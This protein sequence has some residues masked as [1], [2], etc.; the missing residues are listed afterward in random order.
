MDTVTYAWGNGVKQIYLYLW[1]PLFQ[2]QWERWDQQNHQTYNYLGRNFRFDR[3]VMKDIAKVNAIKT[4]VGKWQF[5]KGTFVYFI[6]L[7]ANKFEK[8]VR[9]A[10]CECLKLL[11]CGKHF[12]DC[13]ISIKGDF[14]NKQFKNENPDAPLGF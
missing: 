6:F 9:L 11:V 2:A 7:N 8:S 4:L 14:I 12:H 13:I 1:Y 3:F 10:I 5:Q